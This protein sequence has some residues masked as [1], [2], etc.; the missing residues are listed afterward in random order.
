MGVTLTG[1][2]TIRVL[3]MN[4]S[5]RVQLRVIAGIRGEQL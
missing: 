5:D 2:A 4:D 1:R 3:A